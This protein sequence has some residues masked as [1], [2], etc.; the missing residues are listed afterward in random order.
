LALTALHDTGLSLNAVEQK[1]ET[2]LL[3]ATTNIILRR[4]DGASVT[5]TPS[6]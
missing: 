1:P 6:Y 2:H 4:R 5:L 3:R